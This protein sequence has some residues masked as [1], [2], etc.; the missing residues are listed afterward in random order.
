MSKPPFVTDHQSYS[1]WDHVKLI[2]AGD[3]GLPEFQRTFVWDDEKVRNLWDSIYRSFPIGQIMLWEPEKEEFPMRSLGRHQADLEECAKYAVIDGQQRLTAFWLVLK[4]EVPLRFN[5]EKEQFFVASSP[6][7]N[8]IQLNL[9][10]D[11]TA[12]SAEDQELF[13]HCANGEQ[14]KKFA[15]ALRRLNARLL[16]KLPSQTIK[17]A[18]YARVVEV[19]RRLNV[20]GVALSE[21]QVAIAVISTKWPGV[22]RRIYGTLQRLNVEMGFD[23]L[24]DQDFLVRAW[25]AVH[26]NQH[27]IKHLAPE[28]DSVRSRYAALATAESYEESWRK[29]ERGLNGLTSVCEIN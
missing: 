14:Q 6:T 26:T 19:F 15:A 22:F 8:S 2:E 7:E 21:A 3:Y 28:S 18:D 23:R 11:L 29:L 24:E 17:H 20:Q 25:T 27:L 10:E 4:G 12:D 13:V 1:L 9:L 5:L 16:Q